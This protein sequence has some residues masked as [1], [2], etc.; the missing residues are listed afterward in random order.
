MNENVLLLFLGSVFVTVFLLSQV[1]ILPTFGTDSANRK[2]LKERFDKLLST[3][4]STHHQLIKKKYLNQ[5]PPLARKLESLAP[6][7]EL[8]A[9][10]EI[11]GRDTPAYRFVLLNG[12]ISL[13][14]AFAT[15]K[16][17]HDIR[18]TVAVLPIAFYLPFLWLKRKRN[19]NLEI[20]EEQLPEAL[21]MM[22][23]SLRTGYPFTECLKIV[24]EEMPAPIGKEF[25]LVFDEVNYGRDLEVAFALMMERMPCL[26]LSAMATSVII[27]KETG[28]NMAEILLKISEVMRGR[29]KLKRRV[30]TLS[31]EGV[32]SA[33]VLCLMPFF[34]FAALT[35]INP[36]HFKALYEHPNG[37]MLF[38]VIAFLEVVAIFWMRKIIN[39][40]A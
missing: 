29:F 33:W 31:A 10:L 28:G 6:M 1:L 15:W 5:L 39:I 25:G 37:M 17:T 23:R 32:F 3:K 4:N 26:S 19:K 12:I 21:E 13:A 18:F 38:Y 40:D 34:M 14:I 35:L 30:K 36:D 27:Q 20:F 11:A 2:K 22:A 9:M 7:M 24:A 16:Y 8:K